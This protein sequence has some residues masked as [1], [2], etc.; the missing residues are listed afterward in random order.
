MGC[1]LN[2]LKHPS[3]MG[4]AEK[5]GRQECR[6]NI[7]HDSA[8]QFRFIVQQYDIFTHLNV[9]L[10]NKYLLHVISSFTE[11][12]VK[13]QLHKSNSRPLDQYSIFYSLNWIEK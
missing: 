2:E 9:L 1:D 12:W 11:L 6:R 13:F 3:Q 4:V 8:Q 7:D 10:K 5:E